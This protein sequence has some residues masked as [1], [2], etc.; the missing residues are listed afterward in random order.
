MLGFV[1][2]SASCCVAAVPDTA[3]VY[4]YFK[5]SLPSES[6]DTRQLLALL[7]A[8]VGNIVPVPWM[9]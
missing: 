7:E 8:R 9:S 5:L 2:E 6:E 1:S 4:H 3:M